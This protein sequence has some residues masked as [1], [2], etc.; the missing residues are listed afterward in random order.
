M[1]FGRR[2]NG[3]INKSQSPLMAYVFGDKLFDNDNHG[4]IES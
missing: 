1:M 4:I 3:N 2:K